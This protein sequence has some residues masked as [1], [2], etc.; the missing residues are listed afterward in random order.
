M[1][2]SIPILLK[3]I[4]F[5]SLIG[6]LLKTCDKALKYGFASVAVFPICLGYV[7]K[8]LKSSPVNSQVAVG[9]P[10]GNHF[11]RASVQSVFSRNYL[12]RGGAKVN[13]TEYSK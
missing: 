9:F 11:T 2:I 3:I 12:I 10:F 13:L 6:R 4:I 5:I 8:R 7:A 1:L